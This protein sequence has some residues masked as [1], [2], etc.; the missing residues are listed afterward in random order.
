[1]TQIL[2]EKFCG[3]CNTIKPVEQYSWANKQKG[4][5]QSTCKQC[6]KKHAKHHYLSHKATYIQKS[7]DYGNNYMIQCTK[8]VIMHLLHHPCVDC[9]ETDPLVLDFDHLDDKEHDIC[10]MIQLRRK[11]DRIKKEMAKCEVRCANCHRR[12]TA[13]EQHH[14]RYMLLL[15]IE[16][17]TNSR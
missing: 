16:A 9:G 3:S 6:H 11:M 10:H 1:M 13:K 8:M 17:S 14:R 2:N 15:E 5:R 12:K 7:R 4:V